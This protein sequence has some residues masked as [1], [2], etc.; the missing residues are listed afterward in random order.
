MITIMYNKQ[1]ITDCNC[2][3]SFFSFLRRLLLIMVLFLIVFSLSFASDNES[4]E[5]F[6][7]FDE[8]R[9][10]LL[11]RMTKTRTPSIA[12]AVSREGSIIWEE[13]FGLADR[14][15]LT[16]SSPETIYSLA[17]ITKPMTATAIMKLVERGQIDLD[18]PVNSYLND[19]VINDYFGDG[20]EI[21]VSRL[22]HHTAGLPTIWG[23]YF[24]GAMIQRPPIAESINMFGFTATPPGTRYEYSNLGYG[25][26]EHLIEIVSVTSF[27]KF[28]QSE[29]FEPLGMH[30]TF[31]ITKD[32]D[33]KLAAPRYMENKNAAP[34]YETMSRGGG[35]ACSSVHD[36]VRFGMFHLKNHLTDQEAILSDSTIDYMQNHVDA[37][38][39][40]SRYKLGWDTRVLNGYSVVQHGGGMPGVSSALMLVPEE[41]I[42]IA[43]L[44]NGTYI[45]LIE[46]GDIILVLS[47]PKKQTTLEKDVKITSVPSAHKA[48][49]GDWQG[50][51]KT[52]GKSVP[53]T[54]QVDEKGHAL[55][56][57]QSSEEKYQPI[58]GPNY[59]NGTLRVT[60]DFQI[61]AND[62]S[63]CRHKTH[64]DLRVIDGQLVGYAGA[65]SYRLEVF[66]LPYFT[67]LEKQSK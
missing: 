3:F 43:I 36:L 58:S 56:R 27:D 5:P 53:I 66:N 14:E 44:C 8:F 48:F 33:L 23:F 26:L 6:V 9:D 47:L 32:S 45:D 39:P 12:I 38:L 7:R 42:A 22:L 1:I 59:N 55:L 35:G 51:I 11:E 25:I 46:L 41:Q 37:K 31:I 50:Q 54:L 57:H 16:Q 29:V 13:A 28:M 63:K 61:P 21:S 34:D 24:D 52:Q 49:I 67:L 60:F 18:A 62:V 10:Y 4:P 19:C 64:L 17:S 40:S 65:E 15:N 2:L 20:S 30:N